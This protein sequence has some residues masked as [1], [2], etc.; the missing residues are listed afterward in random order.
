[1]CNL[2]S[3]KCRG[4]TINTQPVSIYSVYNGIY[5]HYI[6]TSLTGVFK[7]IKN[8][9]TQRKTHIM[10]KGIIGKWLNAKIFDEV[11]YTPKD[12]EYTGKA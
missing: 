7:Q 2:Q 4:G 6:Y 10:V 5:I 3:I 11:V 1:M 12:Y 8:K 9:L